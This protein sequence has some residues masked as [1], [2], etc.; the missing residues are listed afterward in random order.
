MVWFGNRDVKYF[1][2]KLLINHYKKHGA[3]WL[4]DTFKHF[5][6][7]NKYNDI[8]WLL[9]ILL[10][11]VMKEKDKFR[12]LNFLVK[13]CMNDL[14]ASMRAL[15][16]IFVSYSW[17]Y[18]LRLLKIKCGILFCNW[19]NYNT[20]WTPSLTGCLLLKC[21]HLLGKNRKISEK[22]IWGRTIWIDLYKWTKTEYIFIPCEF[23][24]KGDLNRGRFSL[25]SG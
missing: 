19:L 18:R 24:A 23:S 13:L 12:D 5:W 20:S 21:G 16:D 25:S 2:W 4:Y 10:D 15:K 3:G 14:K 22:E 7:S 11:Q 17:R 1:H 9:L 6:K 8:G